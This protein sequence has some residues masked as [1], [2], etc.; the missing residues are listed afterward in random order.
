MPDMGPA[1]DRRYYCVHIRGSPHF[2][3]RGLGLY[4]MN[5]R[6]DR[7]KMFMTIGQMRQVDW[8]AAHHLLRP[9]FGEKFLSDYGLWGAFNPLSYCDEE[10][11][12]V[13]RIIG[14]SEVFRKNKKGVCYHP[15]W[16]HHMITPDDNISS[17][18]YHYNIGS[19]WYH[20][21][22]DDNISSRW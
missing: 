19:R 14:V 7:R 4:S 8:A 21:F 13:L 2:K 6:G 15:R 18:W 9:F 17:R 11:G 3:Y 10:N 5:K 20:F 12:E 22:P 16:K 1:Q